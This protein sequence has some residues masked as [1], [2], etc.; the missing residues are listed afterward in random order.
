MVITSKLKKCFHFSCCGGCSI[1]WF[2]ALS[3]V[4]QNSL[5]GDNVA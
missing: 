1:L 3:E 4:V 5:F 2:G